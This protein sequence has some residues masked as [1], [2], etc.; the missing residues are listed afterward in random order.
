MRRAILNEERIPVGALYLSVQPACPVCAELVHIRRYTKVDI[1]VRV[2]HHTL[3][4]C[5]AQ[6]TY[7]EQIY[8]NLTGLEMK[9]ALVRKISQM[10]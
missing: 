6:S 1:I 8:V 10:R 2:Y 7:K 9:R 3:I 5:H 4:R